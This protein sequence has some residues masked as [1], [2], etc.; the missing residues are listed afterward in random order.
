MNAAVIAVVISVTA[1]TAACGG[2]GS[3]N[4]TPTTTTSNG[5]PMTIEQ[6]AEYFQSS[7]CAYNLAREPY[8]AAIA[9]AAAAGQPVLVDAPVP[10]EVRAAA[11]PYRQATQDLIVA[12]SEPPAP[13]PR[14][15]GAYVRVNI[16]YSALLELRLE[17]IEQPN[18]T[19]PPTSTVYEKMGEAVA[20][21]SATIR[22]VLGLPP[23]GTGCTPAAT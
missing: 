16:A 17:A 9:A 20:E 22:N 14:E 6:A 7:T 13:W 11:G 15:V 8:S 4:S 5:V 21:S 1:L 12:L 2:G 18:S 10:P 19:A 3:S 23:A